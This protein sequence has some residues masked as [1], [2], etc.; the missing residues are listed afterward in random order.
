MTTTEGTILIIDDDSDFRA[1]VSV[2][3]EAKGYRVTSAASAREGLAKIAAEQPDLIILD[4]M[5]EHDSAGY[6]VNQAVKFREDYQL[7]HEIPILMV[8]SIPLDPATR[9]DRAAEVG[10]ITPDCYMTK[11]LNFSEFLAQVRSLLEQRSRQGAARG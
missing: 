6:E 1:S 3:L 8:S 9:F 11:P 2:V 10:M 4:I 5:M 7:S